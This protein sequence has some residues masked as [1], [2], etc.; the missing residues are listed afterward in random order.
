MTIGMFSRASLLSVKA[1]R[2]YHQA[3]I[4]VPAEVDPRTGY[5]SY[6]PGQLADAGVILRLRRLDLP[7]AA[8]GRI[9]RARDPEITRAELAAHDRVMRAR[10][11]ETRRIVTDLQ[12]GTIRPTEHTPVHV[13]EEPHCDALAIRGSATPEEF[14]PFL[15][16]AYTELGAAVEATGAIGAGAAGAL[17]PPET[18]EGAGELVA[19]IPLAAPVEVPQHGRVELVELPAIRVAVLVHAGGYD[20]VH[21]TYATLGAW[22]AEHAIADPDA[23]VRELYLV[24]P[25]E[26][27]DPERFRT[28]ICWPLADEKP[29][30]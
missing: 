20:D 21:T 25:G 16:G 3:G 30:V 6:A 28:E 11:D 1:L 23:W 26:S 29:P 14:G 8:V 22:V 13:R 18:P 19:F 4:L 2:A 24:S 15:D 7:L 10:L 17:Y 12:S 5:R 9:M 27:D